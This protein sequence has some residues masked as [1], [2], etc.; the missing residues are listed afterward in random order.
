L[1]KIL[2]AHGSGGRLSHELI[3]RMVG[4]LGPACRNAMDDSAVVE[5]RGRLAFTT[6]SFVVTPVFFPGGDLGRL[7]VCGTVNDLAMSGAVPLYLSLSFI[8]EE[9]L[10]FTDLERVISSVREAA[11]E[12]GACIVTGDTK[13]VSRGAADRLFINTAGL[14]VIPE[15]AR[16]SGSNARPGDAVIFSGTVGDHGT[17]VMAQREGLRFSGDL[18]SDCAPLNGLVAAIL[19]ACTDIHAMRDPTRGGLATTL[20]EIAL[21]SGIGI[22]VEENAIPVKPAVKSLCGLLGL[23]PLYVA[24]EG[25]LVVF[26]PQDCAGTILDAMRRQKYGADAAVIGAV[27]GDPAGRVI[28]KT[29]LGTSR[30][31]PMLSGDLL[32]RIC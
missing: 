31:L 26:V 6:D 19:S 3:D 12:S 28:L 22:S 18:A 32:P 25:K 8:I 13:I 7:A 4:W 1:D 11:L 29:P 21:Q 15:F 5:A 23:D 9:G 2:L 16:I 17:A 24:N 30:I 27:T 10:P 14:G 20:N